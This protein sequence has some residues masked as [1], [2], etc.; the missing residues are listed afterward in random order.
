MFGVAATL[1]NLKLLDVVFMSSVTINAT[2]IYFYLSID[3][4]YHGS[5]SVTFSP[6]DVPL[7][8]HLAPWL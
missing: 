2:S 3:V 6:A 1:D 5:L 8:L 7:R 4:I